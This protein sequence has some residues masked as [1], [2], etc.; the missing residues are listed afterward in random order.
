M[1]LRSPEDES[2][3]FQNKW[4]IGDRVTVVSKKVRQNHVQFVYVGTLTR[5]NV[6]THTY[7]HSHTCAVTRTHTHTPTF[8]QARVH[9]YAHTHACSLMAE[10]VLK[11]EGDGEIRWTGSLRLGRFGVVRHGA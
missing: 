6:H 4:E 10:C 2:F 1:T 11:K 5:T 9:A 8:T 3:L 7:V